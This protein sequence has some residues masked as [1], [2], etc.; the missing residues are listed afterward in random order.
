MQ[1]EKLNLSTFSGS[2]KIVQLIQKVTPPVILI[3]TLV[4]GYTSVNPFVTIPAILL[5][6]VVGIGFSKYGAKK[7]KSMRWYIT[8]INGSLVFL[9]CSFAGK[10]SPSFILGFT[11]LLFVSISFNKPLEKAINFLFSFSVMIGGSLLSEM[12]LPLIIEGAL[13]LA[14]YAFV[15]NQ[16][17]VFVMKQGKEIQLQ[18]DI[19]EEKH[20][21]V[22]DSIRYA[23][24]IQNALI[25][26]EK[27]I[28]NSLTRLM[29]TQYS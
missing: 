21:E 10:N 8:V 24:R 6:P 18:K 5:A 29:K 26:S 22:V 19:I 9:V 2:E 4:L 11:N 7:E 1:K 20:R 15:L 27:S 28:E 23:K 16:V 12:D 25:T 17:L 3:C 13:C 14:L